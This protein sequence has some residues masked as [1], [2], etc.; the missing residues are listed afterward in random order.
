MAE[1]AFR[2]FV[3]T[4]LDA[5]LVLEGCRRGFLPKIT[6]RLQ[7]FEKRALVVSG[8]VFVFHEEETGIKRWTD[9]LSW[10][11]SRTLDN[12]LV[13][14]ELDKKPT[15]G[16][17]SDAGDDGDAVAKPS[18]SR[19]IGPLTSKADPID[20]STQNEDDGTEVSDSKRSRARPGSSGSSALALD[21]ARER[22]L[23][24]SL[25]SSSRFSPDGLV[26]KTISLSGLHL[27]SYYRIDDVTSGRL[28][29]PSSHAELMSLEISPS[30]LA[31]SLFRLPPVVEIDADGHVRYKGD[32][33][34]PL[35]PRTH[36]SSSPGAQQAGL[37]NHSR[38]ESSGSDHK[39][40]VQA[41]PAWDIGTS[42]GPERRSLPSTSRLDHRYSPYDSARPL[43]G[44]APQSANAPGFRLP[45]PSAAFSPLQ[46]WQRFQAQGYGA[47]LPP[48]GAAMG[49]PSLPTSSAFQQSRHSA[50]TLPT[51]RTASGDTFSFNAPVSSSDAHAL[52]HFA[53][54][55]PPY[56]AVAYTDSFPRYQYSQPGYGYGD[57]MRRPQPL[58]HWPLAHASEV[59]YAPTRDGNESPFATPPATADPPPG[60][61][62]QHWAAASVAPY[63][64][65][66]PATG[67]PPASGWGESA[68]YGRRDSFMAG[69]RP[70]MPLPSS[71]S[72][73]S[74]VTPA[75]NALSR[76][77]QQ[78]Q[79]AMQQLYEYS[80]P[81]GQPGRYPVAGSALEPPHAYGLAGADYQLT[82]DS[83]ASTSSASGLVQ[84]APQDGY[85]PP[86]ADVGAF[87]QPHQHHTG[88]ERSRYASVDYGGEAAGP[89]DVPSRAMNRF[90]S[91]PETMYPPPPLSQGYRNQQQQQQQQQQ[92]GVGPAAAAMDSALR[93]QDWSTPHAAV[94]KSEPVADVP[95]P[96]APS[97]LPF[98]YGP[99]PPADAALPPGPSQQQQQQWW[100]N[101][102][103]WTQQPG[104][105]PPHHSHFQQ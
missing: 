13:Y 53:Q 45:D 5:L 72:E 25:T 48:S 29:T 79:Q 65:A 102:S 88:L 42:Q 76:L 97:E 41:L 54:R 50:P 18:R 75:E 35:S 56:T 27:V 104:L 9:G 94:V 6:R 49:D 1:P 16:R 105:P 61:S 63:S 40:N 22:A 77:Q 103:P 55:Q 8:A 2:G 20:E 96:P 10:S 58:S 30:F 86:P 60:A 38:P 83:S 52:S 101:G 85:G 81:S 91:A 44:T 39:P 51:P 26:K 12:F 7:E 34:T 73:L 80:L 46:G 14:R 32:A 28:R 90:A 66:A 11:P 78:Q 21:R 89:S 93:S 36:T 84:P 92:G 100:P 23:V 24:G 15:S 82:K 69:S 37:A 70:G 47:H 99:P 3:E 31:P 74:P 98:K 59:P 68:R 64:S 57:G 87:D 67:N 4:T 17:S 95:F 19:L 71:G 43:H 62:A 33:D